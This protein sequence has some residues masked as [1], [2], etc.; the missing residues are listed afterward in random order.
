MSAIGNVP[1]VGRRKLLLRV[2]QQSLQ[3]LDTFIAS[4]EFPLGYRHLLLQ[5]A[6]LLHQLPLDMHQLLQIP[7]QECH[8]LLLSPT[9]RRSEYVMIL[10]PSL[11]E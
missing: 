2:L 4:N 5:P 10:L 9:I 11:I 1:V 8:L 7:L 6:V 3:A